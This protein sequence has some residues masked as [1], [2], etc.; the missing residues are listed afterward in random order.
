MTTF[1]VI[2]GVGIGWLNL[3]GIS[4]VFNQLVTFTVERRLIF[5]PGA[6]LSMIGVIALMV[7]ATSIP[8]LISVKKISENPIMESEE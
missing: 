3:I 6:A 7:V 5:T 8:I 2:T 4:E 1:A